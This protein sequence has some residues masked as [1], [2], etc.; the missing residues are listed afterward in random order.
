MELKITARIVKDKMYEILP[1]GAIKDCPEDLGNE[2]YKYVVDIINENE[3][4][5]EKKK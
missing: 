4:E 5:R 2:T 1:N 3:N